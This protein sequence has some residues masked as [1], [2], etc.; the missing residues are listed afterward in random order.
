MTL[1]I[2]DI[3]SQGLLDQTDL[4]YRAFSNIAGYDGTT[5]TTTIKYYIHDQTGNVDY[6]LF[7]ETECEQYS[8][9]LSEDE[10]KYIVDTFN[11]IDQLI[12]L[13]CER[14]YSADL[15]TVDIYKTNV[16][17][18]GGYAAWI[19]GSSGGEYYYRSEILIEDKSTPG[20]L[21]NYP[22]LLERLA[23]TIVHEIAHFFGLTHGSPYMDPNDSR[24]TTEDTRMSYNYD[25]GHLNTPS[26]SSLDIKALQTIWGAEEKQSPVVATETNGFMKGTKYTLNGIKDYDGN[27]HGYLGNTPIDVISSYKYQG[28]LDVNN[29]GTK[30]AVYTNQ[31][32]GR[33]V[34]ASID[35]ITGVFDYSKHGQGGTTRI[36]GIY[37]D[38]LVNA[39]IVQKDSVFDGS[40]TFI[41][42]LK[43]DNLQLKVVGDFDSDGFQEIYWSKV[44]NTA[45]LRAVMHADGNIQ[46]ANYQ[47]LDQMTNYLTSHGFADTVAL[48]T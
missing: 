43:I 31:I 1:G 10:E 13:D 9:S 16:Y 14:V 4:R 47:N 28:T 3:A 5:F 2:T 38:P 22:T 29:D 45:Y 36:V 19:G 23:Q 27:S 21:D 12:D 39:G 42:D 6:E 8:Y 24:Y 17:N 41:N 7:D 33:W 26:F 37:E 35:P 20:Y 30:E 25:A 34:T 11:V 18:A 40:R 44:D 15:A 46:Y 32:S 48:I